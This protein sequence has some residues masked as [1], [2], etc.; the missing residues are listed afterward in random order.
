MLGININHTNKFPFS[1]PKG[2]R[3][4]NNNTI[5]TLRLFKYHFC[6]FTVTNSSMIYN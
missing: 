1:K 2:G 5:D 4:K 3:R 6:I